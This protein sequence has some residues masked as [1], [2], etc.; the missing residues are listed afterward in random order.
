MATQ[1][2]GQP[3][4]PEEGVHVYLT[5]LGD[6]APEAVGWLWPKRVPMGKMTLLFGD[7]GRGKSLLALDMA[8]RVTRGAP[9]PDAPDGP[10]P[11]GRVVLLSAEDDPADTIRPRFEAAG[12]DPDGVL[13]LRAVQRPGSGLEGD[14]PFCLARD[15]AA[16]E[17]V[18]RQWGG[19][20]QK[21]LDPVS[22]YLGGVASHSNAAMRELLA[23]VREMA[24]RTGVA[25][26]AISHLT[27]RREATV[28]YRGM[29]SLATVAAARAVWAVGPDPGPTGH[30]Q[31]SGRILLLPVKCNLVG[32]V[33]GLA[34]RIVPSPQCADVP[35]LAWE[36]GS[37]AL[38]AQEAFDSA[39]LPSLTPRERAMAWLEEALGKG[40]VP[41]LEVEQRARAIGF[42]RRTLMRARA[43]LGVCAFHEGMGAPWLLRLPDEEPDPGSAAAIEPAGVAPAAGQESGPPD[44]SPREC[45]S[46]DEEALA[47]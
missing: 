37:L 8:A 35:V 39:A 18:L 27:K 5:R 1:E 2:Y 45:H 3:A 22:A 17:S 42:S 33:P 6:V 36:E 9:W 30:H 47:L 25:V 43:E 20:R 40:A 12:G 34:Y 23:P 38:T 11:P 21:G 13:V 31:A 46:P 44:P 26:V 7:P 24:E 32:A 14:L 29:G 10:N 4:P 41:A 15:V 28:L 19:V 16:L